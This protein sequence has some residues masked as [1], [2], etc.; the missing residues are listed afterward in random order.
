MTKGHVTKLARATSISGSLRTTVPSGVVRD[1]DLGVGDHLRWVILPKE[2][3]TLVV[4]VK[5][6]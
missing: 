2:D 5:K 3:G 6:E 1:L 4:E